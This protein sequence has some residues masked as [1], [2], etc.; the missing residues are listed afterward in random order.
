MNSL[1]TILCLFTLCIFSCA[2]NKNQASS[3][4]IAQL[5]K[6]VEEQAFEINSD[7][8][9]P[10]TT[11]SLVSLQNAGFFP[12]GSSAGQ[13]NLIGNPNYFRI[14]G[15]SISSELP[16]YGEVQFSAGHYG[17]ESGIELK[18]LIEDLTIEKNEKNKS[19]RFRFEAS[20]EKENYK[21]Y[22]TLFPNGR[23]TLRINGNNR[24][25]IEYTGNYSQ[26]P[27]DI[28]MNIIN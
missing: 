28:K 4:E 16:Y 3:T 6:L 19:Y 18:G 26:L 17:G 11:N 13:I 24:F 1:R 10:M 15:D 20:S 22:L 9:L 2:S 12:P 23:S 14:K 25:P 7:W 8:A 21:I 5:N 27:D